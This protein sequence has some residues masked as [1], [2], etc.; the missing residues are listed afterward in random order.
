MVVDA[1]LFRPAT[2]AILA[3]EAKSGA[4]VDEAQAKRYGQLASDDLVRAAAI[5]MR[6]HGPRRHQPVYVCLGEHVARVLHGLGEADVA[7]PVL[8][9]DTTAVA[10]HGAAFYDAELGAAFAS[11]VPVP[12]PPPRIIAVRDDS[13]DEAFD[14]LVLAAL[15]AAISQKRDQISIPALAEQALTHLALL[16]AAAR[17]RLVR[18]VDGAAR[19]AAE[20]DLATFEYNGRT[21]TRQYGIVR[22]LRSPED[23]A[24]QGR[25]QVYQAIARA[26]GRPRRGR[27][28]G[29]DQMA[30]FDDLI[31]ELEQAHGDDITRPDDEE[32][33][34]E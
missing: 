27:S 7:F 8:A 14:P 2:N 33:E 32:E 11:P 34:G 29:S 16:G 17:G 25:T 22:F 28:P 4:N 20:R 13:P 26:A 18:K 21:G 5:T 19:R 31:E 24:R 10:H 15:V 23:A 12:G 1:I 6:T 30:L 9:V 3:V